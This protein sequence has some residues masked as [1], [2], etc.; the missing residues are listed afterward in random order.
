[1]TT[2]KKITEHKH[3]EKALEQSQNRFRV[4]VE[5]NADGI[6]GIDENGIVRF[7]NPAAES[8]FE[9]GAIELVGEMFGFPLVESETTEIDIIR[10]GG[11]RA[12][13]EIRLVTIEWDS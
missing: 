2:Q 4:L 11:S 9:R 6:I 13:A 3:T 10:K 7:V 1:M 8:I 5:K 12:T